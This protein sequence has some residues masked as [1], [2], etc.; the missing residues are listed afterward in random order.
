MKRYDILAEGG[1]CCPIPEL[2]ECLWGAWVKYDDYTE[3][4]KRLR[5][6]LDAAIDDN[7][8]DIELTAYRVA[9]SEWRP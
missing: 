9:R 3:E 1:G 4:V 6:M 5:D 8:E 2:E 7:W